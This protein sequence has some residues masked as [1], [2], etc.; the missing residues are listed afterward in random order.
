[1]TDARPRNEK[2]ITIISLFALRRARVRLL[3][4]ILRQNTKE[5]HK[6][7]KRLER[8]SA[9]A[10]LWIFL[11]IV[12]ETGGI[13][14]FTRNG[15]D[16][17]I[18]IVG[19]ALIGYG[20]IA[21]YVL[22][23]RAVVASNAVQRDADLKVANAEARAAEA[24]QRAIEAQIRL[25]RLWKDVSPRHIEWEPFKKAL[26]GHAPSHVE[27]LYLRD[28]SDTFLL[29]FEIRA[30]LS[31]QGWTV[32]PLQ[33]IPEVSS[34]HP[35]T[36]TVGGQ[37]AGITVVA[38]CIEGDRTAPYAVLMHALSKGL[39]VGVFA[40]PHPSVPDGRVKIVVGPRP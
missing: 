21:E 8:G 28:G 4:I 40:C 22:I 32:E 9:N 13:I 27:I 1:M 36:V 16:A 14:W 35:L 29:A 31:G 7:L 39:G 33:P 19:N 15:A 5:P 6:A 34:D 26:E 18:A 25:V 17:G 24:N 12:V 3:R 38:K 11:G 10:T 20:L 37:P 2:V 30:L 23:L